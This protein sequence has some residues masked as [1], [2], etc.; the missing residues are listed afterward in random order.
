VDVLRP[1]GL[2]I[3]LELVGALGE[4][5]RHAGVRPERLRIQDPLHHPAGVELRRRVAQVGRRLR[6]RFV[7]LDRMAAVAGHLLDDLAPARRAYSCLWH[8]RHSLST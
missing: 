5:I 1:R 3:L 8:W 7:A 6:L 2:W 4:E